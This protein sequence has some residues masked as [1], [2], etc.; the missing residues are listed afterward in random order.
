MR[1]RSR[2]FRGFKRC[3][4]DCDLVLT[5]GAWGPTVAVTAVVAAGWMVGISEM[6][7]WFGKMVVPL[8]PDGPPSPREICFTL[9]IRLAKLNKI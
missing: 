4:N 5:C 6:I 1:L 2:E 9:L 7:G 8:F 3:G